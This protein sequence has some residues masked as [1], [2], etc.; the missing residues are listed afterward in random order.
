MPYPLWVLRNIALYARHSLAHPNVLTAHGV[1]LVPF[2]LAV[3]LLELPLGS[4]LI[5]IGSF[6]ICFL[7]LAGCVPTGLVHLERFESVLLTPISRTEIYLALLLLKFLDA[8]MLMTALALSAAQIAYGSWWTATL[9][10]LFIPCLLQAKVFFDTVIG[11]LNFVSTIIA[12]LSL[13]WISLLLAP[14]IPIYA[15]WLRGNGTVALTGVTV[16]NLLLWKINTHHLELRA[17]FASVRN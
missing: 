13:A 3:I 7:F 10:A 14:S 4:M 9:I 8:L 11:A 12:F 15:D 1:F 2:A 5:L 17:I 6:S 16:G